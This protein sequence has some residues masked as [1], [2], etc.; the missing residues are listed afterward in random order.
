MAHIVLIRS[1]AVA[2]DPPVEKAANALLGAGHQVTILGWDRGRAYPQEEQELVLSHGRAKI[3]RFGIPA[4]FSG[5][6]RKNSLQL[7]R[8]QRCIGSWLKAHHG[9]YDAIHAFDFDTGFTASAKARK[10]GKKLVYHILDYY[11]DAHKLGNGMLKRQIEKMERKIINTADA[12]IICTEKRKEQIAGTTP[13]RLVIIHNTPDQIDFSREAFQEITK[14]GRC[15]IAYIGV[16]TEGRLLRE[17]MSAVKADDRFELHIGGFGELAEAVKSAAAEC[18]R[19]R[20]YGPLPYAKTLALESC[21][22]V[23]TAIYNPE[24]RNHQFAAPNKFYESLMQGKPIIMA[25]NTGFD[26]IIGENRIG[27]VIDYSEDGLRKGME[28]LIS[29]KDQWGEMGRRSRAL[30]D[31]RYDWKIMEARLLKLYQELLG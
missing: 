20:Y 23:M 9:E 4:E 10:Y 19:I 18:D 21:C 11:V 17:M 1:N 8:F 26:E 16:I 31:Q 7:I 3:V 15:K 2:P 13:A 29:Q 22:D 5:G 28:Y 27:C 14:S 24:R 25:K 6:I 12:T 30:Y